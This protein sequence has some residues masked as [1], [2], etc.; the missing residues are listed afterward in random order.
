MGSFHP[1]DVLVA[2]YP[3]FQR[4]VLLCCLLL[5]SRDF[6]LDVFIIQIVFIRGTEIVVVVRFN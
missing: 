4:L 6:F 2:F 3:W 1:A 5:Q